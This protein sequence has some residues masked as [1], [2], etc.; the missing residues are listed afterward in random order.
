[1]IRHQVSVGP[2][3][4]APQL[5]AGQ[6]E[7][8]HGQYS[9]QA[10]PLAPQRR[11]SGY[12]N[13]YLALGKIGALVGLCGAGAANLRRLEADQV[14]RGEALFDTLRTG[15]AAGLAAATAGFVGDQFRSPAMSLLATLVTGT[16]MMY[17]QTTQPSPRPS[18][19]PSRSAVLPGASRGDPA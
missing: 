14:S 7:S 15:V 12:A 6:P 16:A 1:M 3:G 11:P 5:P 18:A 10:A 17:I 4:N 8:Y 9:Q 19:Q 13:Q 2:W